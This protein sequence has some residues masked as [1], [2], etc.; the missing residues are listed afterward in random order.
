MA[1][2]Q[3]MSAAQTTEQ[4][5]QQAATALSLAQQALSTT[6]LTQATAGPQMQSVQQHMSAAA[7]EQ[8]MLRVEL[9]KQTELV[10]RLEAQVQQ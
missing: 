3:Q 7:R 6:Q 5:Q 2:A 4:V 8:E 10:R 1:L 9:Q